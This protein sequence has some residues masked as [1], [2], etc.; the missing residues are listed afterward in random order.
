[1]KKPAL[2]LFSIFIFPSIVFAQSS[3]ELIRKGN[4]AYTSKNYNEA[5]QQYEAAIKHDVKKE[6]PQAYFNL[7]NTLFKLSDYPAAVRQFQTFLSSTA[8]PELQS[9]AH[10]NIGTSLLGEKNYTESIASFRQALKL[11]PRNE[12]ARYNLSYALKL[13]A[14]QNGTTSTSTASQAPQPENTLPPENLPPLSP[15]EQKQLLNTLNQS[16]EKAMKSKEQ[17]TQRALKK[18]W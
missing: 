8:D 9:L 4:E 10:Y 6:Y 3:T 14:Q 12:N 17:K 1:M 11:N 15:E 18:D 13:L 5:K 2:Y 16:E 7:G